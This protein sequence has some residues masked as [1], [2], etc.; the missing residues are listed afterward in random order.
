MRQYN[1]PILLTTWSLI[2][3]AFVAIVICYIYILSVHVSHRRH[4]LETQEP[5]NQEPV[6]K[7]VQPV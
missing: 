7:L 2:S 5:Q 3:A 4:E 6:D 1:S